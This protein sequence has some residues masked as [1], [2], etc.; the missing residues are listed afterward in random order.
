MRAPKD[1]K[2]LQA[3]IETAG[4]Y[5]IYLPD[6]VIVAKPLTPLVSKDNHWTWTWTSRRHS[7]A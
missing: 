4:Y 5:R 2:G 7:N 1:V 3:F 6:F